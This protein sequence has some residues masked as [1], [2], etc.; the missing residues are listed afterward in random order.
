M[1]EQAIRE[2]VATVGSGG[3]G[4]GFT[5]LLIR[6]AYGMIA[7]TVKLIA[8]VMLAF[9]TLFAIATTWIA[10]RLLHDPAALGA[11]Q[12]GDWLRAL[13]P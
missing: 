2:V 5:F 9:L 3:L 6:I 1:D 8:F 4:I 7:K 10:W 13:V 11:M 12:R